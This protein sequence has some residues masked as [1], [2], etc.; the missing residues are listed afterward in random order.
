MPDHSTPP[1]EPQN[2]NRREMLK[3]LAASSGALGAA[4]FLPGKWAKPLVEAGV[5]PAH[6]QATP[7]CNV[8]IGEGVYYAFEIRFAYD[9]PSGLI[10]EDSEIHYYSSTGAA[11]G[12]SGVVTFGSAESDPPWQPGDGQINFWISNPD[13]C[14]P[15]DCYVYIV[16]GNCVTPTVAL[17]QGKD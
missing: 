15:D 1:V 9:D 3:V 17:T 5:L 14:T 10:T 16:Y 7:T 4:A 8:R 6:A 12:V 2:I 11:C 13:E